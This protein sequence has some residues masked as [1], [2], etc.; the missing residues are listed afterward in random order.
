VCL[1]HQGAVYKVIY[2]FAVELVDDD[3][4]DAIGGS[5]DP[6]RSPGIA[7]WTAQLVALRARFDEAVEAG[8]LLRFTG[9]SEL[10]GPMVEHQG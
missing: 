3:L 7:R 9:S 6:V 8:S 5:A 4:A 10:A 2:T 1:T